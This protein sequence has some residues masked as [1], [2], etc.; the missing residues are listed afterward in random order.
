MQLA[1]RGRV[2][3][4][5]DV[6]G[7]GFGPGS[8]SARLVDFAAEGHHLSVHFHQVNGNRSAGDHLQINLR[9]FRLVDKNIVLPG[10]QGLSGYLHTVRVFDYNGILAGILRDD[11]YFHRHYTVNPPL[12]LAV[13]KLISGDGIKSASNGIFSDEVLLTFAIV[14][15]IIHDRADQLCLP[16]ENPVLILSFRPAL[17]L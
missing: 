11:S 12:L 2:H 6:P 14:V 17:F 3:R 4:L 13:G 7:N 8:E 16:A 15:I 10:R 5:R 1:V 9:P